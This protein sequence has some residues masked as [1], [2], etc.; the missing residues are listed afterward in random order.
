M[1][2][3]GN[4]MGNFC[5]NRL[6]NLLFIV[7]LSTTFTAPCFAQDRDILWKIISNCLDPTIPDYDKRCNWPI[8]NSA[9]TCKKTS[10][11]WDM[12]NDF[13]IL[14]DSKM[15]DCL[16]N[17]AFVHGLAIPRSK[18]SGSD[19]SNRPDDI[20]KYAWNN[21]VKRFG[22]DSEIALIVNAPGNCRGQDQLHIHLVRLNDAGH[23]L[24][25]KPDMSSVENLDEVWKKADM[26][27]KDKMLDNYGVL[28][29]RHPEKQKE[30]II[31]V[32]SCNLEIAYSE[33]DCKY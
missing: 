10:E 5:F 30:Y 33:A 22:N 14:R 3:K 23:N 28:I 20:W 25:S 8:Q 21:A 7:T 16:D 18:V 12:N 2:Q 19:A 6:I 13:I 26:L 15:C 32:E 31:Y 1:P 4:T 27:A 9:I 29:A 11:V 24:I 17:K